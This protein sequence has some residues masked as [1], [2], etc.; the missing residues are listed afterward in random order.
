[1]PARLAQTPLDGSQWFRVLGCSS[2]NEPR[3][4]LTRAAAGHARYRDALRSLCRAGR[5]E[6]LRMSEVRR[7]SL[8]VSFLTNLRGVS[9]AMTI[10]RSAVAS[11]YSSTRTPPRVTA[12]RSSTK[13][14]RRYPKRPS[15]RSTGT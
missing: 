4:P 8:F 14:V 10:T 12:S 2:L 6:A 1:M 11:I 7:E 13:T 9:A 3:R 5:D 15:R